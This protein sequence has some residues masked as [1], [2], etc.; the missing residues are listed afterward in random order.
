MD[1]LSR[2]KNLYKNKKE[3]FHLDTCFF[4]KNLDTI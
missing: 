3:K 4:I 2:L 1:Q